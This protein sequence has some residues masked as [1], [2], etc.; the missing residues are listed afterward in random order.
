MRLRLLIALLLMMTW[1]I[2]AQ[3]NLVP[4]PSF[5]DTIHC[6]THDSQFQGFVKYWMGGYG[7]Y[8]SEICQ[9]NQVGVPQND[10]GYQWPRT[11]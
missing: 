9:G 3:G 6:V 5:E 8:Y 7:E 1:K 4:N 10:I 2:H 11:G